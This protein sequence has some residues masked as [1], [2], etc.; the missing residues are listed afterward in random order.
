MSNGLDELRWLGEET[1]DY[2]RLRWASLRLATVD[3]LSAAA[4]KALGAVV[5][6]V[7]VLF[8]VIFLMIALALW[9]GEELG[10]ASLGFLIAGGVFLIVGIILFYVGRKFFE[11][12]MVRHFVELFFTDNDYKHGK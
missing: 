10:H 3:R 4:S 6:F 2:L 12:S 5:A 11:G 7:V 8:A 1:F 9:I